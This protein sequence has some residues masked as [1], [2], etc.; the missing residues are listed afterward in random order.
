MRCPAATT[1]RDSRRCRCA[2]L[3][4]LGAISALAPLFGT[5]PA[6]AGPWAR[7]AGAVFLSFSLQAEESVEALV[8]GPVDPAHGA[9]LYGEVGL[10]HGLTGVLDISAAE[11][12]A[13]AGLRLRYSFAA[14]DA[15]WQWAVEAG[16]A[17]RRVAGEEVRALAQ[18]GTSV[19][20]GFDA[21]RPGA[22]VLGHD[23]GWAVLEAALHTDPARAET[24]WH[25]EGT[26]GLHLGENW[27]TALALKAEAGPDGATVVTARPSILHAL[28]PGTV[29]QLGLQAGLVNS[30][31]AGLTLGIWREF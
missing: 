5:L 17:A 13:L 29:L 12:A 21:W 4:W 19:G 10:G 22:G 23:G 20:V 6:H 7:E 27:R 18:L 11:S 9:G 30:E 1:P 14:P 25:V 26:L 24:G 8:L 3:P 31:T 2:L 28:G 16:A 15:R